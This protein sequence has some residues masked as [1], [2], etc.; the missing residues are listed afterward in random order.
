MSR[1]R[2]TLDELRDLVVYLAETPVARAVVLPL[3]R[4]E[5][6]AFQDSIASRDELGRKETIFRDLGGLEASVLTGRERFQVGETWPV[7]TRDDCRDNATRA[8]VAAL[9]EA[10]RKGALADRRLTTFDDGAGVMFVDGNKRATAIYEAN[11]ARFPLP[12]VVVTPAERSA[13][14]S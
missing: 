3:S 10:E 14:T 11:T 9:I 8:V 5:Y 13:S 1:R 4:G 12:V 7:L 6:V 2:L